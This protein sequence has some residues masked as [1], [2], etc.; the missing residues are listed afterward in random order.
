M[1]ELLTQALATPGL[2]WLLLA[3]IVAGMVRG[4]SGFGSAMIIMP[5]AST[6]LNPV[7]AI[8]F[9]AVVDLFGP[10]P[11]IRPAF[12]ICR[13]M[14]LGWLG[15]GVVLALPF[16]IYS[17]SLMNKELFSWAVSIMVLLALVLFALGWRYRGPLSSRVM[18][19]T[20]VLGGFLG[21]S[22]GV[23]GPPVIMLY[24]AST[25][26]ISV[27]RANLTLYLVMIDIILTA[28]LA[29]FGL[30][31]LI[32]VMIGLLLALPYMIA[33][34]VGAM[35]FRPDSEKMFRAVAYVITLA[36]AIIGLPIWTG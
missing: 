2:I 20:G 3:V 17:L 33:N 36:A 24:M 30:F 13:R 35:L 10:L 8:L 27:I 14:D 31:E 4:F 23:A 15:L 34:R 25:L 12:K 21:G 26:P 32:P 5:V 9:L 19:G 11:N 1:P 6:V 18:V 7:W 29:I 28:L 22:V 16:G